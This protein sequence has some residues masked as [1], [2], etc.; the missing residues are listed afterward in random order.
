[1]LKRCTSFSIQHVSIFYRYFGNVNFTEGWCPGSKAAYFSHNGAYASVPDI[2]ITN[3]DFTIAFWIK[4]SGVDGPIIAFQKINGELFYIGIR[5][6]I[7]LLSVYNTLAKADFR[8]SNWNHVVTTC[9]KLKIK[10]FVNGTERVLQEQWNE[11]LFASSDLGQP[12][13]IIGNNPHFFKSRLIRELTSHTF[14][15]S[16]MDLNVVGRALS[17]GEIAVKSKGNNQLLISFTI[18]RIYTGGGGGDSSLRR[19]C[20]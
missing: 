6:S 18:P 2:N 19:L 9:E 15:G 5:D 7:V 16:V 14:T 17:V 11:Y 13:C 10:V 12:N 4:P 8:I 20:T 3:C 1:M